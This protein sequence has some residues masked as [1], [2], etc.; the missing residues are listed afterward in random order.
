LD[1]LARLNPNWD[2]YGAPAID[3]NIIGAA[4]KFIQALPETLVL[5]R[6]QLS[7]LALRACERDIR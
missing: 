4:R 7:S 5:R 6:S 2:G 3:P 1:D